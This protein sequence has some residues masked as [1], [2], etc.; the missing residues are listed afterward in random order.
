MPVRGCRYMIKMVG[1]GALATFLHDDGS[2]TSIVDLLLVQR[3]MK[4]NNRDCS[5]NSIVRMERMLTGFG[6]RSLREKNSFLLSCRRTGPQVVSI[7]TLLEVRTPHLYFSRRTAYVG[8]CIAGC[9]L[10]L[11]IQVQKWTLQKLCD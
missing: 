3:Y 2:D 6:W 11:E 9:P 7:Y 1:H 5:E 10:G 8:D 4:V